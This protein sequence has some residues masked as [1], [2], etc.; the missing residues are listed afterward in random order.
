VASRDHAR[1][2][3]S[4]IRQSDLQ[5]SAASGI[6]DSVGALTAAHMSARLSQ[7]SR[8]S[9]SERVKVGMELAFQTLIL[10]RVCELDTEA[11]KRYPEAMVDELQARLADL[12]AATSMSDLV[13]GQPKV[14]ARP[15]ASISFELDDG[16]ILECVGNHPKPPLQADGSV[17]L[18]RMRRVKIV[19]IR[20]QHHE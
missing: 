5:M 3:Q 9:P 16:Y 17:D 19:A 18:G 12:H 8:V 10:R 15:P 7:R 20:D 6:G 13:A 1:V 14:D 2:A 11:R 4:F